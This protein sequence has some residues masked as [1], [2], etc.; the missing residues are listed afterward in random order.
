[1]GQRTGGS[2]PHGAWLSASA[3]RYAFAVARVL[4]VDDEADIREVVSELLRHEGHEVAEASDGEAALVAC[5]AFRPSLVLL[6]LMMP[7]MNGWQYREAQLRE[8]DIAGIPVVVV[9][10]LGRRAEVV[11]DAYLAKPFRVDAL[12]DLVR[13]A[14]RPSSDLLSYHL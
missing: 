6:D 4:I 13:S 5:R 12:L 10:A 8:P 14:A 2:T 9:S 3:G 7:G 11:A 1:M